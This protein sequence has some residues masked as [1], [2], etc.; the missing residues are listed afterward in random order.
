MF[1]FC[2]HHINNTE[3]KKLIV[4][5]IDKILLYGRLARPEQIV[6]NSNCLSTTAAAAAAATSASFA[7]PISVN[8]LN[9][10]QSI[11]ILCVCVRVFTCIHCE[12]HTPLRAQNY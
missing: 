8:V 5:T 11:Y 7:S 4:K 3:N 2:C 10:F 1:S 6:H 12:Q 9:I